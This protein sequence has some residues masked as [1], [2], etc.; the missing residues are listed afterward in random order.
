MNPLTKKRLTR[1]TR[2]TTTILVATFVAAGALAQ[3]DEERIS[4]T[5][6]VGANGELSLSNISGD[7]R[8][9]ATSGDVIT[10]E[11]VKRLRGRADAELLDEVEVDI[12]HVVV[13]NEDGV[14]RDRV[15]VETRYPRDRHRGGDDR[16]RD[17]NHNHR[18]SGVSV[19][20]RVSVPAGTEVEV[21]SVSG[22]VYVTG[23]EGETSVNSVSGEIQVT[24][25]PS[26]VRAKSV[27]GDVE[28]RRARS[29]DD[30]EI[31]SVSGEVTASDV[32]AE[33]LDVSSVSGDVRLDSVACDEGEF[34]SVSGDIRYTGRITSGGQYEF[35]SHSGNVVITIGDEVGFELEANTFSGEVE[36]DFAMQISSRGERGRNLSAVVG[37]GSAVIEA[38]TFSG[39]VTL[40]KR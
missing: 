20:Y 29:D 27:S 34:D 38:T 5:F 24:D 22:D 6:D 8:V 1:L 13:T 23:V 7:I 36:S 11:A 25:T 9:E 2:L 16:D 3:E 31:A 26:L 19:S 39:N 28:V 40:R 10:V 12:S 35:K 4:R 33:E 17:R 21:G 18:R 15:R 37:D 14:A 30:L 32:E